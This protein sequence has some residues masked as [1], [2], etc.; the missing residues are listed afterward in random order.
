VLPEH[1]GQ[2]G[3]VVRPVTAD[4]ITD[5]QLRALGAT[6]KIGSS[7]HD[8]LNVALRKIAPR[9]GDTFL[10]ARARCASLFN[11]RGKS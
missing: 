11:S 5:E 8:D 9:R 1:A 10:A 3:Q 7:Q 2:R 6:I 4:T